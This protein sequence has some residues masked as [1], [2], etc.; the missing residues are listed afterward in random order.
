M[1][2]RGR[3]LGAKLTIALLALWCSTCADA[4][5][6]SNP[7]GRMFS[8]R[9]CHNAS[10]DAGN[11]S[12]LILSIEVCTAV[13]REKTLTASQRGISLM[14]RGVAYRNTNDLVRSFSDLIEA[15]SLLPDDANVARMLAWTYRTM[16]RPA[17]AEA[18]YDRALG[19]EPHWQGYLSRCVARADLMQYVTALA[20]CEI[21]HRMHVSEDSVYFTG[22][23]YAKL[24]RQADAIR[25]LE[26]AI[27]APFASGRLFGVL[28][29]V[30]DMVGRPTDAK[31]TISRG[32]KRFPSDPDLSLPP[33]K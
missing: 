32:R 4:A 30:Y 29:D 25:I 21:A 3:R 2:G 18:E 16:N 23:L 17:D 14:N 26:P 5:E 27:E 20:D 15:R 12:V 24:G 10:T 8:V 13:L 1:I 33:P 31:R 7:D 11:L 28:A 22:W 6:P 19:L 9:D